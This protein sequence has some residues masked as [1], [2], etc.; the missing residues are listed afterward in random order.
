MADVSNFILYGENL[1][2]KDAT[3]RDNDIDINNN[4]A[5]IKR[6]LIKKYIIF[7]D[8]YG[9]YITAGDFTNATVFWQAGAN[10][11]AD[12]SN[13]YNN[14]IPTKLATLN[15]A[16]YSDIIILGGFNDR[17]AS[18]ESIAT[19]MQNTISAIKNALGEQSQYYKIYLGHIGWSSTLESR[20]RDLLV[21]N[22]IPIYR[23]AV[24]YGFDGYMTNSEY[25]MHNYRN[26]NS[27]NVHPNIGGTAEIIY[28]IKNFMATGTCDVHYPYLVITVGTYQV[29][30]RLDNDIV[31][32]YLP[33]D[34]IQ[35]TIALNANEELQ[36][37]QITNASGGNAGYAIGYQDNVVNVTYYITLNGYITTNGNPQFIGLEGFR[38]YLR[39]GF[40]YAQNNTINSAGS[41]FQTGT[42][43]AVQI[44]GGVFTIPTLYC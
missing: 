27:D 3:A 20:V 32:I 1:Q 8:S 9:Q 16:E 44:R 33:Y 36:F 40:L 23:Q 29:A 4:I 5:K 17:A 22:S 38:F 6:K 18:Q 15:L 39:G 10:F 42:M 12:D 26:F 14:W 24:R 28:Q 2:I 43:T 35:K 7:I 11:N 30:F 13:S 41:G 21:T 19:G 37:L 25:T 31:T 34:T